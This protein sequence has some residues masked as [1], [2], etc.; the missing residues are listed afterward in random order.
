VQKVR[1]M[2]SSFNILGSF[3]SVFSGSPLVLTL[4]SDDSHSSYFLPILF[5]FCFY[6]VFLTAVGWTRIRRPYDSRDPIHTYIYIVIIIVI[7]FSLSAASRMRDISD[8]M[9]VFFFI[10]LLI[11]LL[12]TFSPHRRW[13]PLHRTALIS[14]GWSDSFFY[15][16]FDFLFFFCGVY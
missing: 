5:C 13:C 2:T 6:R 10:L 3:S 11:L 4:S 12:W 8:V 9:S 15:F 7:L 16:I 14:R 1:D